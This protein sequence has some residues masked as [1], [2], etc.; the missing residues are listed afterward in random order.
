VICRLSRDG[1]TEISEY[2]MRDYFR[3]ALKVI[4]NN[5]ST[6]TVSYGIDLAA[7]TPNPTNTFTLNAD[8]CG[9]CSIEPGMLLLI[10]NSAGNWVDTGAYVVD[11]RAKVVKL[12]F[13]NL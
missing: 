3:D 4:N 10:Q 5:P 2:G 12:L 7:L 11:T 13:L 1:V 9:C 6:V 8:D